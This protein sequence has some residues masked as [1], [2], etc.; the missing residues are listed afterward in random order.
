MP[1]EGPALRDSSRDDKSKSRSKIPWEELRTRSLHPGGFGP[2]RKDIWPKLL[3]VKT[4]P[5]DAQV[6]ENTHDKEHKDEYQIRL[7]T[8]RSFVLYPEESEI[9]IAKEELKAHLNHLIVSVFHNRPKLNYFQG[10]HDIMTVIY[11]TIP[12]H[13]Q[14]PCAEKLSLQRL[15]DSM[16]HSLEPVIGLLRVL[17][18]LLRLADPE[19]AKLLERD[20][21][22]PFYALSNLLTLFAHDMPTLPLI[23]HVFDYLLCR[24]PIAVVYLAAAMILAKKNYIQSIKGQM[25]P[26]ML[27]PILSTLPPL[28]EEFASAEQRPPD[29]QRVSSALDLGVDIDGIQLK[30]EDTPADVAR[31][32]VVEDHVRSEARENADGSVTSIGTAPSRPLTPDPTHPVPPDPD[33]RT[34][35]DSPPPPSSSRTSS[36]QPKPEGESKQRSTS[37][38]HSFHSDPDLPAIPA[39]PAIPL[40]TILSHSDSL[41]THFPPSHP[42]LRLP[43]I[44]GPQ[45]VVFTWSETFSDLPSDATAEAMVARPELVVYPPGP[46]E[47][48]DSEGEEEESESESDYNEDSKGWERRRRR[49]SRK[50]RK[51]GNVNMNGGGSS[52]GG[53]RG[54]TIKKKVRNL[55]SALA[56]GMGGSV[57]T[58]VDG[59]A[60]VAGAVLVLGVAMAIYGVKAHDGGTGAA[61]S[62]AGASVSNAAMNVLGH[63]GFG[64]GDLHGELKKVA[65]VLVGITIVTLTGNPG[66][67]AIHPPYTAGLYL[68][69]E[70]PEFLKENPPQAPLR[71]T[72]TQSEDEHLSKRRRLEVETPCTPP[73]QVKEGMVEKTSPL[74]L[75]TEIA[76]EK[77]TQPFEEYIDYLAKGKLD[78]YL[79]SIGPEGKEAD[80]FIREP[81]LLLHGLGGGD[82]SKEDHGRLNKLFISGRTYLLCLAPEKPASLLRVFADIRAYILRAVQRQIGNLALAI[83]GGDTCIDFDST[84]AAHRAF[85]QLLYARIFM[86]KKLLDNIPSGTAAAVARRR[87][88]LLQVSPPRNGGADIFLAVLQAIQEGTTEIL[89]EIVRDTLTYLVNTKP[90]LFPCAEG[91]F[92]VVDEAQVAADYPKPYLLSTDCARQRQIIHEILN[93]LD[94]SEI[95]KGILSGTSLLLL[96]VKEASAPSS[97]KRG[98]ARCA[99]VNIGSFNRENSYHTTYINRYLALCDDASDKRLL[100]CMQYWLSSR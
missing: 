13:L 99:F 26:F 69:S 41:L 24:P 62:A 11:L 28:T 56:T 43:S 25:E 10:Y 44:M 70:F 7:D 95:F 34:P 2:D 38:P 36:P 80:L 1:T 45:S 50:S 48:D 58:H 14:L 4:P 18:I 93:F 71:L 83:Q 85:A 37:L 8:D 55:L 59:R 32:P 90:D 76:M 98:F 75:D 19:Y 30:S 35:F 68:S 39:I 21:P 47:M 20:S 77:A 52:G 40:P 15:R 33:L 17:K 96:M 51:S 54:R 84:G 81:T 29:E 22:L 88:V 92:A 89:M 60:M 42:S 78:G 49:T 16:L 73:H 94:T 82:L 100:Q 23:Q 12:Q 97:K 46:E 9:P 87:W 65:G 67:P 3:N 86:L 57:V 66:P 61:V 5:L 79:D 53:R 72:S 6:K 27:H 63:H 74:R 31:I 91:L 64:H